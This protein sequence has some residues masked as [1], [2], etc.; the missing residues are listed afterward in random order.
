M[1]FWGSLVGTYEQH[2]KFKNFG[3]RKALLIIFFVAFREFFVAPGVKL[4][5]FLFLIL[6][7]IVLHLKHCFGCCVFMTCS[8]IFKNYIIFYSKKTK[9]LLESDS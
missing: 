4:L 2:L 9:I 6:A 8:C 7:P 3:S 5:K 1:K